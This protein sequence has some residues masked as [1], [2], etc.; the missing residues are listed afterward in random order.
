MGRNGEKKILLESACMSIQALPA[1]VLRF[2]AMHKQRVGSFWPPSFDILT[3]DG[4]DS[5]A[6]FGT[7]G[8][9]CCR[10]V[11]REESRLF[12]VGRSTQRKGAVMVPGLSA[13]P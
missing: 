1:C 9:S 8:A 13:V 6:L 4:V 12:M 7:E 11:F 10:S 3:V 2:M 5:P